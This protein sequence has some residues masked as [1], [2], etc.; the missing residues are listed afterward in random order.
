MAISLECMPSFNS[1][2]Y[3]VSEKTIFEYFLKDLPFMSSRQSVKLSDL[4]KSRMK[5]GGQHNKQSRK[6]KNND[7]AEIANF[8]FS[9][10]MTME[11][12]K[13]S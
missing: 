8:H 6:T 12:Y 1:I 4:D 2:L 13:S 3:M 5:R 10:Y 9:H 7:L 11:T